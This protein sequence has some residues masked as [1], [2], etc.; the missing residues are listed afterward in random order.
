MEQQPSDKRSVRS[1]AIAALLS[2]GTGAGIAWVFWLA[3][4]NVAVAIGMAGAM[5]A[6]ANN[7]FRKAIK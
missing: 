4:S 5:A 1:E 7:F 6:L 3:T 2:A